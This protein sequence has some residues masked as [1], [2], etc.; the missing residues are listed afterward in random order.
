MAR[1]ALA[2][3]RDELQAD[4]SEHGARQRAAVAEVC[5]L[6]RRWRWPT[7]QRAFRAAM[8]IGKTG[9]PEPFD[10]CLSH[11]R[12]PG[13]GPQ[14]GR[15]KTL[16]NTLRSWRAEIINYARSGGVSNAF[17]EAINHLIKNQKRQAHGYATWLG[18]RSQILWTFGDVV[19]PD[20]GEIKALRSL[21]RGEG[22]RWIQP[23]FATPE[24]ASDQHVSKYTLVRAPWFSASQAEN[25][26]S[27]L[28][29]RSPNVVV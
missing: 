17:A 19:D 26:S 4:T 29:A 1:H 25:A 10:T 12:T 6:D 2:R 18:F 8:V 22:A 5:G 14:P 13:V 3:A 9:D 28:V 20:T 24:T 23:S 16:A 21:P 11:L 27:I 15:W 7:N